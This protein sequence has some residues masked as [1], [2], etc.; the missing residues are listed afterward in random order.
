ML[1]IFLLLMTLLLTAGK[2]VGA[3]A[4]GEL[5]REVTVN[6]VELVLIPE[7]WFWYTVSL[8][9]QRLPIGTRPKRE[10]RVWLDSFYLA[11]YEARARDLLRFMK[12]GAAKPE[13][14]QRQEAV[15]HILIPADEPKP[16]E[17]TLRRTGDAIWELLDPGRDLPATNLS[18][19]LANEFAAWLGLRLP[20][21]AEWEKAA[22]GQDKRPWP[23][24][25]AYPDDTYGRFDWA[26]EGCNQEAVDT[27]PKGRSPYGLYNMAGNVSEYVAD[28]FNQGFDDALKNGVRNPPLA[29]DASPAPYE[30]PQKISKGGGWTRNPKAID[31]GGRFL[32][33]PY[34]SSSRESVR[35]AADVNTVRAY[36]ARPADKPEKNQ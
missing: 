34:R 32:D 36:L 6:G 35:F 30:L 7:G 9:T 10:V 1:R 15:K 18:W 23:W 24:G 8:D 12:A 13:T 2:A 19:A 22:R 16:P 14:L 17:C 11:K 26:R 20:T 3:N 33:E 28:W 29:L 4:P 31:I 21:E 5:P 25:D 27:Y